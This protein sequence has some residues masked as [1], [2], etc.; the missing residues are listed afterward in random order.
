MK[1][2]N[3]YET[4]VTN[5]LIVNGVPMAVLSLLFVNLMFNILLLVLEIKFGKHWAKA[6]L[7]LSK[8]LG[9]QK[10]PKTVE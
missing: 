2:N 8:L 9:K 5:K 3:P 6:K 10:E 4:F 7:I 1:N